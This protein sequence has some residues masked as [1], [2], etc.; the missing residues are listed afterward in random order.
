MTFEDFKTTY[1]RDIE[2]L[3]G[4]KINALRYLFSKT[5][6]GEEPLLA[7]MKTNDNVWHR[8]HLDAWVPDWKSF[9]KE[10]ALDYAKLGCCKNISELINEELEAYEDEE[11]NQWVSINAMRG[12]NLKDETISKARV[13]YDVDDGY[14]YAE[15]CIKLK[16]GG[17][18]LLKDF[19]GHKHAELIINNEKVVI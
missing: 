8:F 9:N 11:G 12:Y 16:N 7:W 5:K 10:E 3:V 1:E 19:G 13:Q 2:E 17:V 4:K 18:M 14:A 6:S 15:I